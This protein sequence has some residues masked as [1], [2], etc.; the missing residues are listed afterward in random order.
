MKRF[1]IILFIVLINSVLGNHMIAQK[2]GGDYRRKGVF[3]E[4]LGNGLLATVNY[5]MRFNKNRQDGLG[6]RV[7]IGGLSVNGTDN[8]GLSVNAGILTIP[9]EINYLSGKRRSAFEA[10][11]GLTPLFISAKIKLDDEKFGGS[12]S[13]TN[14]FLSLGYRYQPINKGFLFRINWTPI[15]NSYGIS[16]A[17]FGI[18]FGFSFR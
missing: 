9:F 14:G 18:S 4:I 7:G 16:P 12:G 11:L 1:H 15:I 2:G 13:G 10:G 6:F 17:W 8:A 5:D 3:L